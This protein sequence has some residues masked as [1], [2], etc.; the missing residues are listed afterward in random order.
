MTRRMWALTAT[1]TAWGGEVS[2]GGGHTVV[3]RARSLRLARGL[4]Q[5]KSPEWD[6]GS[7]KSLRLRDDADTDLVLP[8]GGPVG[9]LIRF[10]LPEARPSLVERMFSRIF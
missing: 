10:P 2:S 9:G 1:K 8:L 3:V 5:E 4:V 6:W 7:A